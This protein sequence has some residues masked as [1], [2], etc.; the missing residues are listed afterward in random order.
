[1][2]ELTVT[3][4]ITALAYIVTGG[5][6][7]V[8]AHYGMRV[9]FLGGVWPATLIGLIGA[10]LGGLLATII[11]GIPELLVIADAVDI[12]PPFVTASGLTIIY[13]L[14]SRTNDA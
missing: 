2:S 5:L 7:P 12:V 10:V 13:G 11:P 14:I 6:P 3:Y 8:A 4:A 1:M 9:Q